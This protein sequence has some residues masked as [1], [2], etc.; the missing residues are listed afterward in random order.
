[1]DA[2]Y[3]FEQ[4]TG[5]AER[6]AFLYNSRPSR[7]FEE[8]TGV[9]RSCM[10]L[11][12]VEQD[13]KTFKGTLLFDPYFLVQVKA[14]SESHLLEVEAFLKRRFEGLIKDIEKVTKK[15]L[16]VLNHL[17]GI[18]VLFLKL[19]FNNVTELMSV[20][21]ELKPIILKN[22]QL[23]ERK[24]TYEYGGAA[25]GA[26]RDDNGLGVFTESE[27]GGRGGVSADTARRIDSVLDCCVD[28]R[29]FDVRYDQRV[30]IDSGCRVG[31]W[32]LVSGVKGTQGVQLK[33][34]AREERPRIKTL[35]YD[36][37]CTKAPLKFPVADVDK[38]MMISYMIDGQGYLIINREIVSEDIKD[39]EYTPKPEYPGPFK[40]FNEKDERALL[41]RFLN[42]IKETKPLIIVTYNGDFFDWPFV[43]TRMRK[44]GIRLYNEIAVWKTETGEYRGR[45][46]THLDAFAWVQRDSYLPQGSQGLKAVTRYKLGYDPI[47]VDPEDMLPFATEQPQR[48]AAY[49]V[50]DAVAT[51]YLYTKYV[52]SF[53]FSLCTI[54]PL[55]PADVLRKGSGTLCELLLMVKAF[56]GDIICPDKQKREGFKFS[57]GHLLESE[58]YIGGHVEGLESGVFRDDI[59]YKFRCNPTYLEKLIEGVDRIIEF[60]VADEGGID[61]KKVTNYADVR[62]QIVDKL[63]ALRDKPN[64][65]CLPMIYHLDVGAMYPN[66]ILTN[67][68]Q[69]MAIVDESVCAACDFNVPGKTCQ[70]RMKWHWRGK[71]FP[72]SKAEFHRIKSQL[73]TEMIKVRADPADA[74][75]SDAKAA[76]GGAAQFVKKRFSELTEQQQEEQILK[77]VKM[78]SLKA[79]KRQTDESTVQKEAIVC[80]RENPFYVN[81][82]RTFRDRRYHY[83]GLKK[84]WGKALKKANTPI[85]VQ[86]AKDMRLLYDSMQ[87][88]HKCILNSFYGYVMRRGARWRSIEM[89]GVVTQTG[90]SI[91]KDARHVVEQI[92]RPLELDTDGIWCILPCTF[93]ENFTVTTTDPKN[94]TY[95]FSYSNTLLNVGVKD[96]YTNHQYQ[97]LDDCITRDYKTSSRCTIYFEVDGPYRCMVLPASKQEGKSIKK[98]YAVFNKDGSL[99]ELKGF[100]IKRRGELQ[101]IKIFQSEV[102]KTFLK[103]NSLQEVYDAVGERANHWLDILD[104]EGEDLDDHDLF[105]LISENKSMREKLSDYMARGMK[106]TS[107]TCAKRLAQFLGE[108]MVQDK[109]LN[110]KFIISRYPVEDPVSARSI[111]T[112]IFA[113]ETS[114]KEHFLKKW[115]KQS[116]LD[117]FD[118]R[119]IIDWDYYKGRL[120][121]AIMKIVTIPAAFQKIK[122]PVPRAEHPAWLLKRLRERDDQFKQSRISS[123]FAKKSAPAGGA[124]DMEDFGVSQASSFQSPLKQRFARVKRRTRRP[125]PV[126]AVE[127]APD[128]KMDV[129]DDFDIDRA[130]ASDSDGGDKKV[131]SS[132][133]THGAGPS[134][135]QES[136]GGSGGGSGGD[137]GGSRGG[138]P[139]KENVP[140]T[141]NAQ[142]TE[143]V[144][145][146]PPSPTN[147]KE[148]QAWLKF[149]SR[150]WSRKRRQRAVNAQST[151][152]LAQKKMRGGDGGPI[153]LDKAGG[154]SAYV[155]LHADAVR[156]EEW[157]IVQVAETRREPGLFRVWALIGGNLR[158]VMVRVPRVIYI[159]SRTQGAVQGMGAAKI[160]SRTLPRRRECLN[161]YEVK[162]EEREFVA[163]MKQL[164]QFLARPEIE[165]VYETQVPLMFK[166]LK[167]VGC[168][169]QFRGD[170]QKAMGPAG[171]VSF[172]ELQYKTTDK[173]DYLD[174]NPSRLK[175]QL[176]YLYQSFTG[177]RGVFGVF[178][179]DSARARVVV[180]SPGRAPID[181]FNFKR[182]LSE[183]VEAA[184]GCPMIPPDMAFD[185]VRAESIEQGWAEVADALSEYR[186]EAKRS[187]VL[188]SQCS[189]G[190][191]DL[192]SQI[193]TLRTAMPVVP[194]A[195]SSFDG[196][197]P[198]LQWLPF[199]AGRMLHRYAGSF[200]WW[201][202]S[203]DLCRFAHVPVG[204]LPPDHPAFVADLFYARAL[205]QSKHLLWLSE[206]PRPDLGGKEEDENLFEAEHRNPEAAQPGCYRSVCVEIE[207]SNLAVNAVMQESLL[208]DFEG[209][210]SNADT[211][212]ASFRIL[213]Q[214]ISSWF[215]IC[216]QQKNGFADMLLTHFYRWVRSPVSR[217][218]D[219]ALHRLVHGLMQKMFY[220]MAARFRR[221]KSFVVFSSFQK[222]IIDTRKM[223]VKR[224]LAYCKYVIDSLKKKEK[225]EWISLEPT[226]IWKSLLFLDGANYGGINYEGGDAAFD[227]Q[228]A[229]LSQLQLTPSTPGAAVSDS[230]RH[231]IHSNWD[232]SRHLPADVSKYFDLV[233]S[234]FV[235]LPYQKVMA[236]REI[237]SKSSPRDDEAMLARIA[238]TVNEMLSSTSTDGYFPKKL[239][240]IVRQLQGAGRDSKAEFPR[241][242]GSHLA[243]GSPAL[244]FVK[245]VSRVFELDKT[246][247]DAV[248]VLRKQMFRILNKPAYSDE[249]AFRDPC[250]TYV[251]PD[252]IC[253][254]CNHCRDLDLCRD[255]ELMN[256]VWKCTQCQHQY[257][258]TLIEATLVQIVTR[259]HTNYQVQDLVCARCQNV[260]VSQMGE[261]CSCA[262][263]YRSRVSSD[264]FR[265]SFRKFQN[266][267]EF[268]KFEWLGETL[269]QILDPV[270]SAP[271]VFEH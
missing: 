143:D 185:V 85:E 38:I 41:L 152:D 100:E 190:L 247:K 171:E 24:E 169:C 22:K 89:A 10:D 16:G 2:K 37:E 163:N 186:G 156:N 46:I 28:I 56:E 122:N 123:F 182:G 61:M 140:S 221:L 206:S 77:R 254:Y 112:N 161:L 9:E 126:V 19:S 263:Q 114:I 188:L 70:R 31:K 83:K 265:T 97:D 203:V 133:D 207:V 149:H 139:S 125:P 146:A 71:H 78:Y 130:M 80:Q 248:G 172:D 132:P 76:P 65:E 193:P 160:A 115:T 15:D 23:Q 174:P 99:A 243:M 227:S 213:K 87:L 12:F 103:G 214:M 165:G 166:F 229:P 262:G 267:A 219:P 148:Y 72:I 201:Q 176:V 47:E 239:F 86:K 253:G 240:G 252:V 241:L 92:G 64:I 45:F 138:T 154:L 235:Y 220:Q 54:L 42:H 50:S 51:Y 34:C 211:D 6:T 120:V 63:I 225:F 102:F 39:F 194:I 129:D 246:A 150:E 81:T 168:V 101:L 14:R 3:G 107:I 197:Y 29:E 1:M 242:P 136:G 158:S 244:E 259:R 60:A 222:L 110:C 231:E 49:S 62:K 218:H 258:K 105:N 191:D 196:Q 199:A 187:A 228:G 91:I 117:D 179:T 21:R 157:Q 20:R 215:V 249:A 131:P 151:T 124:A 4:Y 33:T 40:I 173:A 68:L 232:L 66:I 209:V 5:A 202:D 116:Q 175:L 8:E 255:P 109:G 162:M 226:R 95:T 11:Y 230:D 237:D 208:D 73:Q 18:D 153:T 57:K 224:A 113:A 181:K 82:V 118:I 170:S 178:F 270:A 266:I 30:A 264:A 13:G 144:E 177:S 58:T 26:A 94:P 192:Y 159:N 67:R 44:Y 164:G 260:K 59:P 269:R 145:K 141:G 155:R 234:E 84:K 55:P 210:E 90:G 217:M 106:S 233:V 111:P 98:R 189:N 134:S 32:Y 79:Y 184:N 216:V 223:S 121:S 238:E 167:D 74:K 271:A 108:Q 200:Q 147:P 180:V 198:A 261:F 36:I 25:G 257:D 27:M 96:K 205:S 256:H 35:A 250:L 43:D 236:V 142:S 53:I 17:S 183:A 135:S 127:G 69:P 212:L 7:T 268:H 128:T 88:A 251:L 137:S 93:P 52:H 245:F 104:N 48:L 75:D 204:N 195:A 119:G